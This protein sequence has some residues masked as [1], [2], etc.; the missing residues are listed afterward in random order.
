MAYLYLTIFIGIIGLLDVY[1]KKIKPF[2][3]VTSFLVILFCSLHYGV[4]FDFFS[5]ELIYGSIGEFEYSDIKGEYGFLFLFDCLKTLGFSYE[6]AR[7][8]ILLCI[9]ILFVGFINRY[10]S[11]KIL[12][13]FLLFTFY[14][15]F[16]FS[17]LRQGL[18]L[19]IFFCFGLNFLLK[20]KYI[21]F[22]I[23]VLLISTIHVSAV[24]LLLIPL[25]LK[26]NDF[27]KNK[28][29]LIISVV[30][31]LSIFSGIIVNKYISDYSETKFNIM[32]SA[33]RIAIFFVIYL[34]GKDN[35]KGNDYK[36]FQIY[37]LG[38]YIYLLFISFDLIATRLFVYFKI[39]DIILLVRLLS[40][41]KHKLPLTTFILIM[42]LLSFINIL[43]GI[44]SDVKLEFYN[45]PYFSIF[46]AENFKF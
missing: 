18:A 8:L 39:L 23:L 4:G 43:S 46:D 44:A 35:F 12:S 7:I 1:I 31:V 21:Y 41:Y 27:F 13:Q 17:A 25:Y 40:Y 24:I 19:S 34:L 32:G 33:F 15:T 30:F 14:F 28:E 5:Y 45:Y 16:L 29:L 36:F 37:V 10:S 2:F 38:F 20:E 42:G 6:Y 3:Y 22:Y 11:N 9:N 26:F